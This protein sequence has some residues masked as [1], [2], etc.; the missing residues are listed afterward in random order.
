MV[1]DIM[2]HAA[3]RE[4]FQEVREL[5]ITVV[6]DN[7]SDALRPDGAK[8]TRFR[9]AA[10][11]SLHAEHGLSY[12]VRVSTEAATSTFMFDYGVDG[13]GVLNNLRLLGIEVGAVSAFG[14]SHGHFDHWA[15]LPEVLKEHGPAGSAGTPFYVGEEAFARRYAV[16]ASGGEP[17]D[18]GMLD[19]VAIEAS[20]IRIVEVKGPTEVVPGAYFSGPIGRVTAYE[21]PS[22]VFLVERDGRLEQDDFPGEQALLFLVKDK[23]LVVLSGCAHSGIVN[24]VRHAR[25]MTGVER[26]HA[27]IGGFHLVNASSDK[28]EATVADMRLMAP[29]Y[30][31]PTHCTGFEAMLRFR[32]E[33]KDR[34]LLNTAGTTYFFGSGNGKKQE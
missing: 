24:A 28:I 22:P 31:V 16:P 21:Q 9:P 7:Y 32:E 3:A 34:F 12:F 13:R 14:L 8:G 2:T 26:V 29:D 1:E 27:V 6:T 30:I 23:G 5:S 17:M 11:S 25:S 15:A 33:M 4:P 10:G 19:R 20:H 18:L